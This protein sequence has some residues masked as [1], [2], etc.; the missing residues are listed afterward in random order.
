MVLQRTPFPIQ[1]KITINEAFI[2][3]FWVTQRQ[4]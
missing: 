2:T 3:P 4:V 1:L